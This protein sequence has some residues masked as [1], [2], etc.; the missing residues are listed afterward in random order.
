VAST[1]RRSL[2]QLVALVAGCSVLACAPAAGARPVAPPPPNGTFDYQ[3]GGSYRPP[4]GTRIV[5]RDRTASPARGVYSICYVNAFQ[6][7]PDELSWWRKHHG[8]L[9]LKRSGRAVHDPGWPGEVLL[10]TSTARRRVRIARVLGRWIDGCARKG[11]DAVEPDNLDSW[12]RSKGRLTRAGNFRL[13]RRLI[14]RAHARRLAIGQKN[15]AER[16]A[17]GRRLGFDFAVAESCQVYRECDD[18][19]SAYGAHVLEVEYAEEGGAANFDAACRARGDE[20]AI[21]YRDRDLLTPGDPGY[22]SRAC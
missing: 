14:V 16:S 10:D 21:N 12:T 17:D 18:Y 9:L 4:P 7:Q 22:V 15:V 3:L 8:S 13:A 11:F 6:T 2:A 19:T 20:I 1:G 5:T